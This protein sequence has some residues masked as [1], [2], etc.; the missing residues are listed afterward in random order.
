MPLCKSCGG[1]DHQRRTST[2]CANYLPQVR[3]RKLEPH[4]EN[5]E[6]Q[7]YVVK[8]GLQSA[9]CP[10]LSDED[11]NKL[12]Y[13]IRRDVRDLSRVYIELG[14][15]MN[16]YMKRCDVLPDKP[17][18]LNFF[19]AMKGK[20]P[21][22]ACYKHL[23]G[24][25]VY[26]GKLR[27]FVVQELAK[28]YETLIHTNI[29]THAYSR[30]AKYFGV[31]KNHEGL[32]QAY[33]KKDFS[34]ATEEMKQICQVINAESCKKD[35]WNT[36]PLW[37]KIQQE[38]FDRDKVESFRLFPQPSYGL[39][40]LTYT[41]RGWHELLRRVKPDTTPS[42]WMSID[43][44][45][46][47]LWAPWLKS[48]KN[49]GCCLQT[50]GVS[51]SLSMNR[52]VKKVTKNGETK[53]VVIKKWKPSY[54]K[55]IAVDPGSR[56]PVAAYNSNGVYQRI[57]SKYVKSHSL[58]WKR[59]RVR[60]KLTKSSEQAEA[61]DRE[62]VQAACSIVLS[63]K[64]TSHVVEYTV[65]RL[66]W[67]NV[68]QQPYETHLKLTRLRF[69]KYINTGKVQ[70]KIVKQVFDG[71]GMEK[72]LVLYGAGS[73]FMNTAQFSGR[74]FKHN[75]LLKK[76][77]QKRNIHV[78]IVDESYTSQACSACNYKTGQF[79]KISMDHKRRRGVC[80][81]CSSSFDRDQNAAKNILINYLR[82]AVC[83]P[84]CSI[85][86]VS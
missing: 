85:R 9:L 57:T 43:D 3:K 37:L 22:A 27:S 32:F 24:D 51:V 54:D 48:T 7:I 42:S 66:K 8:R 45:I 23:A 10:L 67:F 76:L 60:S 44:H 16:Y 29:E 49:F 28:Q 40:H 2:K 56:I 12:L 70:E 72:T 73:H 84:R 39:K 55:L 11:R 6:L 41:S 17:D 46:K 30:L 77:R 26:D 82:S 78:E 65:F 5:L 47:E 62:R 50:D 33:Y 25:R 52:W 38:L 83:R 68:R 18:V 80:P 13:E 21:Y 31:K 61:K 69:D 14:I 64:N 81:N 74:K 35:W 63:S 53:E 4:Q 58:E 20:G 15:V 71:G 1:L 19:Y 75:A 79:S 86:R 59:E 34:H 36:I